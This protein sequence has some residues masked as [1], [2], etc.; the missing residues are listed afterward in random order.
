MNFLDVKDIDTES[1]F[2]FKPAV[3]PTKLHC[4]HEYVQIGDIVSMVKNRKNLTEYEKNY[5][6]AFKQGVY[7]LLKRGVQHVIC[8][9]KV[10]N[11]KSTYISKEHCDEFVAYV[12]DHETLQ[13]FRSMFGE[14][15]PEDTTPTSIPV[16]EII[17]VVNEYERRI[18]ML[19]DECKA[20][21]ASLMS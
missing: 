1:D 6:V 5:L 12:S 17:R 13:H 11:V 4:G 10:S 8:A 14:D 3:Y 21:I 7:K 19:K 15:I 16:D 20:K 9:K 2:S 18:Q